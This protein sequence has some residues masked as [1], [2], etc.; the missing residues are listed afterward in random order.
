MKVK[1]IGDLPTYPCGLMLWIERQYQRLNDVTI[2]T[3]EEEE[4][5]K[6]IDLAKF[7]PVSFS[8][9]AH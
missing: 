2:R 5:L 1:M 6:K 8:S 4:K 7:I 9:R 3:I